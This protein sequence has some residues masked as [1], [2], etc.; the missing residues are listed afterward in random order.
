MRT[1][2]LNAEYRPPWTP[3]RTA[4]ITPFPHPLF[5][6]NFF[7]LCLARND[8]PP[9]LASI[10]RTTTCAVLCLARVQSFVLLGPL[11]SF[12]PLVRVGIARCASLDLVSPPPPP[13]PPGRASSEIAL[14][15]GFVLYRLLVPKPLSF[16]Y[17]RSCCPYPSSMTPRPNL[18]RLKAI[19]HQGQIIFAH[20]LVCLT[21]LSARTLLLN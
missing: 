3:V 17:L 15:P 18:S 4:T 11:I 6:F 5:L 19:N 8:T 21:H 20:L 12:T 1:G 7:L 14:F 13:P 9:C 2:Y 10:V 16:M